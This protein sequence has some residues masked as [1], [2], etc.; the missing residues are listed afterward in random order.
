MLRKYGG[1]QF[2]AYSAGLNPTNIHPY[3]LKVLDEAGIDASSQSAKPL[4]TY[5]RNIQFNYL[6]TV[7]SEAEKRCPIFPGMGKRF[8]W[9][10]EDP[11]SFEGSDEDKN[12]KFRETRDLIEAKVKAWLEE[13]FIN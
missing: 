3:T 10:F 4:S 12:Q 1:D 13:L 6:I 5:M 11:A 2:K 7:C 8:H 9:P